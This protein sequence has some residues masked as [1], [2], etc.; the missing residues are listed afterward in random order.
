MSTTNTNA[1]GAPCFRARTQKIAFV[2]QDILSLIL[3]G[4]SD[5]TPEQPTVWTQMG[6][7]PSLQELRQEAVAC[8]V[9]LL[10]WTA[11]DG[12]HRQSVGMGQQ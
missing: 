3:C 9:D 6:P 5:V 7:S 12:W 1:R 8:T 2:H 10:E 4:N 11:G